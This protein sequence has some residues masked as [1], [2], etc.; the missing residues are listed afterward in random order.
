MTRSKYNVDNSPMG[1]LARTV[2][3]IVFDSQLEAN[4]YKVLDGLVKQ[5]II[6]DLEIHPSVVIQEA[7]TDPIT[8]KKYRA[9]AMELDFA[10]WYDDPESGTVIRIWE[11]VKGP[12]TGTFKLKEKIFRMSHGYPCLLVIRRAGIYLPPGSFEEV[13]A[14]L[15]WHRINLHE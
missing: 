7:F 3:D 1:R 12:M 10:Y 9:I 4:R 13:Q 8:R 6:Q 14:H 5:G 2:D 15:E 11:D